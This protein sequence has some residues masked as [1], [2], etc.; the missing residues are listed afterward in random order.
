M[1]FKRDIK[2]FKGFNDCVKKI[3]VKE[4]MKSFYK[5]YFFSSAF[6]I[7]Y[8]TISFGIYENLKNSMFL[9][10]NFG[11]LII[12]ICLSQL[13]LYPLDT[14]RFKLRELTNIIFLKAP[15]LELFYII[16]LIFL[17]LKREVV[18]KI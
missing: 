6:I 17:I 8:L 9:D 18:I 13:F 7:P 10:N 12:S 5:G 2:V 1:S 11:M 16:I 3:F 15:P 14:V 4:G